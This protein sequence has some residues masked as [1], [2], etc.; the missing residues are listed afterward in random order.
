MV[1]GSEAD[2]LWGDFFLD[3]EDGYDDG[4]WA[5]GVEAC[6]EI[7]R[8]RKRLTEAEALLRMDELQWPWSHDPDLHGS[9]MKFCR[10]CGRDKSMGHA[11][12]CNLG[13]F[14]AAREK[15]KSHE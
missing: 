4:V 13:V 6:E 9:T 12:N 1:E 8:L 3:Q 7:L 15:E 11:E 14:L 2:E 5:A 10:F